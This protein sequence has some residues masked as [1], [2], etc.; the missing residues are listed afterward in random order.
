MPRLVALDALGGKYQPAAS[1]RCFGALTQQ[2]Q[3]RATDV[4]ERL[5]PARVRPEQCEVRHP[6]GSA[7]LSRERDRAGPRH[8][9]VALP[10][11]RDGPARP[12]LVGGGL[13][14]EIVDRCFLDR[15]VPRRS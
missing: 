5:G 4:T 1:S 13:D 8:R 14:T 10:A 15:P 9:A 11:H 2:V 12:R 7:G 3:D 6:I